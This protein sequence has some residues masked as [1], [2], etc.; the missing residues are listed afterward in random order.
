SLTI[1][2]TQQ[3]RGTS[4]GRFPEAARGAGRSYC[5]EACP[6]SLRS[7][8]TTMS[9]WGTIRM[10]IGDGRLKKKSLLADAPGVGVMMLKRKTK[11]RGKRH[12]YYLKHRATMTPEQL[13]AEKAYQREYERERRAAMTPE[14][15][16][17]DNIYKRQ[18][19]RKRRM[20]REELEALKA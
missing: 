5:H 14:E 19:Q 7:A 16:Q 17:A 1:L 15:R 18:H 8:P 12:E 2:L 3:I 4:I 20:T 11:Q 6:L 13:A 9:R 10:G